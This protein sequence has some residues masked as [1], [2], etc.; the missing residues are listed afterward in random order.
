[1]YCLSQTDGVEKWKFEVDRDV[2]RKRSP[3]YSTPILRRGGVHLAAGEGHFYSI[4]AETGRLRWKQR[5]EEKSD[6]YCSP[7]TE[8]Q[9]FFVTTRPQF[10]KRGEPPVGISALVAISPY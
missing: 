3:I 2:D 7:V 9:R 4:E 1:M 8:G 10:T 5:A 6:L